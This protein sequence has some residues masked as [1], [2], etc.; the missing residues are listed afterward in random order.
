MTDADVLAVV[1]EALFEVAP[2]RAFDDLALDA[3]IAELALDS[4]TT[5]E[6][7]GVLED[8]VAKSFPED[9]LAKVERIR[10]LGE[11]MRGRPVE[12]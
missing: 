9:E 10:D 12:R 1:R 2:T 5:M 6:M 7:V 3:T 11:L 8:R 4:I